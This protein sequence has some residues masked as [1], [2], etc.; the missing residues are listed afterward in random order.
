MGP[1]IAATDLSPRS[2][3]ALHRAA[4]IARATGAPLQI[5][6]ILDDEMPAAVLNDQAEVLDHSL[7]TIVAAMDD[8]ASLSPQIDV[9]VGHVARL[10]PKIATDRGASLIVLGSHRGRGLAD[11][12][13][14]PT[15]SRVMGAVGVPILVAVTE[16]VMPWKKAIVGWDFSPAAEA[17]ARLA[18]SLAPDVTLS[19]LH[20]WADPGLAGPYAFEMGGVASGQTMQQLK[21]S[22]EEASK[23]LGHAPDVDG[24]PHDALVGNPAEV[25]LRQARAE[26]PDV[27]V[28]GRHARSGI[29]RVL[30]GD[31][32]ARAA[33]HAPCD[34]LIAPPD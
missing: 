31:T 12:F 34:V 28:I 10:L 14:S 33:L 17:A 3:I 15:L 26:R 32:A 4:Q 1:I 19:L 7:R 23:A 9:E 27:L 5:V 22:L 18:V 20:A 13:G 29:V 6:H 24:I 21:G 2:D 8:V 25:I 16:P 11:L 30:M